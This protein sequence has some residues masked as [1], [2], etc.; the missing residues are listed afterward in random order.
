MTLSPRVLE[1]VIKALDDNYFEGAVETVLIA[2]P[3]LTR[4]EAVD[5]VEKIRPSER[6]VDHD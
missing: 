2:Y 3:T 5:I 6:E 1:D 4:D